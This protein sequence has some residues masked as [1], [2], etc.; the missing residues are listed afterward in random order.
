MKRIFVLIVLASALIIGPNPALAHNANIGQIEFDGVG[1]GEAYSVQHADQADPSGVWAGWV[2][3][4]VKNT[5]TEAWGDFHFNIYEVSGSVANVDWDDSAPHTP[6][7]SQTGLTWNVDNDPI[8]GAIID[9]YFYGD[10]VNPG[11]EATFSV[12]NVNPDEL[13]YFGVS[14]YPTPV[15]VPAAVWLLGSGLLGLIG[16]HR[17]K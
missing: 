5:G 3:V 1:I 7:S 9:L 12:Y 2:N 13:S 15:P 4:S 10:P 16:L 6:T 11:E 8:D 14:F 17:K